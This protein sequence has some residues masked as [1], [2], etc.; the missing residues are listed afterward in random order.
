[1]KYAC[2]ESSGPFI[3][4]FH[5]IKHFQADNKNMMQ[6]IFLFLFFSVLCS[7]WCC[8]WMQFLVCTLGGDI[9]SLKL[10]FFPQLLS[11]WLQ[12]R[13]DNAVSHLQKV[14]PNWINRC[15]KCSSCW[16]FSADD[17]AGSST[18]LVGVWM[19][20]VWE[21]ELLLG[22]S[23]IFFMCAHVIMCPGFGCGQ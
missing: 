2:L 10:L 6:F 11:V 4:E 14:G 5:L 16:M 1:M 12:S 23:S 22:V 21:N 7:P 20:F 18:P 15:M 19:T 13:L 17:T 9:H 8:R 3:C